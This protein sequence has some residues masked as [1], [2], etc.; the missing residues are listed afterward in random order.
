MLQLPAK[1]VMKFFHENEDQGKIEY[2]DVHSVSDLES[3]SACWGAGAERVLSLL[4]MQT[5][6]VSQ[7][8]VRA[9][10]SYPVDLSNSGI[11]G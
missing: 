6:L 10:E 8:H 9:Q 2:S 4:C 3:S 1:P 11:W 7:W 5:V